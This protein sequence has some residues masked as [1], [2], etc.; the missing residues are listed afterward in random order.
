M[1]VSSLPPLQA[2]WDMR[3][4]PA[5]PLTRMEYAQADAGLHRTATT[6]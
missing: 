6:A 4:R 2:T 3:E 5:C 1:R